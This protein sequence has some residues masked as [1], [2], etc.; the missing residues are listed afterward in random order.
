[1]PTLTVVLDQ[2]LTEVPG[3]IGRYTENLSRAL[4]E[5]A[6]AGW[7]VEGYIAR[8]RRAQA[9]ALAE[10]IPGLARIRSARLDRRLL[11]RAWRHGI[12]PDPAAGT[13]SDVLHAPSLLAPLPQRRQQ[14]GRGAPVRVVTVHDTVPWTHPETLTA[15]GVRWHRAM[16]DRA[17]RAADA[18]VTPTLA[19]AEQLRQLHPF[20][21]RLRVVPGAATADLRLPD[22]I[23]ARAIAHRLGL[24]GRYILAV[25]TLEPRKGL[26]RLL[27][28]LTRPVL[29]DAVL[30]HVGPPGWGEVSLPVLRDRLGIAPA[31]LRALGR[32]SDAE[33]AVVLDRAT[34]LCLPSLDE[35]FGLPLIEAF[36]AGLATVHTD[37]PALDEVAAGA[38]VRVA[39][40]GEGFAERLA[41]ALARVLSD[42]SL[43]AG[44]VARGLERAGHYSWRASA[45]ALWQLHTQLHGRAA[46]AT[47]P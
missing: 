42:E 11:A 25:G 29:Q 8:A 38:G 39:L 10:R 21:D 15:N 37:V 7:R 43:R 19:V 17:L 13:S 46:A 5:Q 44:L 30:V 36:Q 3:G 20:G 45:D 1:M 6:P 31:R 2:L 27:A 23:T 12:G 14:P 18:V 47:A 40:H 26:D 41:A 34:V 16:L 32:L 28:A 24:P 33:L 9:E 35:G 22:E 4:V